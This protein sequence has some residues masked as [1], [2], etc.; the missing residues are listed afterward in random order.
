MLENH[1]EITM[2]KINEQYALLEESKNDDLKMYNIISQMSGQQIEQF[3]KNYKKTSED[4][5]N[6]DNSTLNLQ[7]QAVIKIENFYLQY[8]L[9][10]NTQERL[11]KWENISIARKNILFGKLM[12]KLEEQSWDDSKHKAI[13]TLQMLKSRNEKINRNI[14]LGAETIEILNQRANIINYKL[15]KLQLKIDK[16]DIK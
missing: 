12:E 1:D 3:L 5:K 7:K 15:S 6:T 9:K 2:E 16:Y 13:R 4:L 11:N 10:K 14:K 8:K